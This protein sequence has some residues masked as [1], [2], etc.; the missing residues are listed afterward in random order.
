MGRPAYSHFRCSCGELVTM[1]P[2]ESTGRLAP[3][4]DRLD[5]GGNVV[6]VQATDNGTNYT[7]RALGTPEVRAANAGQLRFPHWA[8]CPHADRFRR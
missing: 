2:S 6:L 5:D 3:I 4:E 1:V 7:Y 8:R